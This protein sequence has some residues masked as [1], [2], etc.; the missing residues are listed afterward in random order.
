M[1]EVLGQPRAVAALAFGASIASHGFNL[2]ALGQPVGKDDARSR[3]SRAPRGDRVRASRP[4]L[5]L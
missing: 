2:F 3:V 4:L 5:R 1:S